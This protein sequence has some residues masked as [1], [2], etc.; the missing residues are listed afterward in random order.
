MPTEFVYNFTKKPCVDTN[1]CT[2]N[3]SLQEMPEMEMPAVEIVKL[4]LQILIAF[5][6]V[7][8]NVLVAVVVSRLPGIKKTPVDFYV[9]TLAIA[10]LGTL[11]LTFPL[12]AIKEKLPLNWPFGEFACLYLSPVPEIFFGASVWSIT[13]IAIERYRR[14][15][16]EKKLGQ[17]R[18][19]ASLKRAKI[20]AACVWVMSFLTFSLPLYFVVEYNE[21]PNR[22]KRC[23]PI[24]PSLVFTQVYIGLLTVFSYILP[25]AIIS[26]TYL[27]MSR[28]IN[29]SSVFF[30]SIEREQQRTAEARKRFSSHVKARSLRLERNKRVQ[31]LLTPVVLVFAL[32]MLPLSILRLIIMVWPAIVAQEYYESL[33][34]VVSV[35]VLLN[36][37]T[38]PVI[39]FAV[40]S[41]F[42]RETKNLLMF[43][44]SRRLQ[45]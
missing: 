15:I 33:L 20:A 42:R 24:W 28:A 6:G 41:V 1:L 11:L 22:G 40:S 21:L 37:S 7:I 35:F 38:N 17:N 25:L 13:I 14:I 3:D 18:N 43:F 4:T 26:F 29:Q 36:S 44:G 8:G 10:D 39:Y 9:Q 12:A 16:V 27:R 5:F 2:S 34:Y 31:K 19:K 30:K 32:T 45:V 23:G